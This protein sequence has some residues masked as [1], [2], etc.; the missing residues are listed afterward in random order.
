[1]HVLYTVFIPVTIWKWYLYGIQISA[2]KDTKFVLTVKEIFV[3]VMLIVL[4]KQMMED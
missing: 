2:V 3:L 1:M 4:Q